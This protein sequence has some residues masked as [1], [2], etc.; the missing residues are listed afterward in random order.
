M[1]NVKQL[2]VEFLDSEFLVYALYVYLFAL[3]F[4]IVYCA[5]NYFKYYSRMQKTIQTLYSRMSE[6]EKT[7]AQAER[8]QRDIHGA[9]GKHDILARIDMEL[10]YSGIKDK[11]RW[12][13]T[14]IYLMILTTLL[15]AVIFTSSSL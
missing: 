8:Q 10:A 15:R 13:T 7:R 2:L 3:V 11:F 5:L 12:M 14:E 9:G 1:D 6:Q 4:Y